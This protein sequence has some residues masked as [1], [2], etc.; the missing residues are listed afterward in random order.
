MN[1][2]L[3]GITLS[4]RVRSPQAEK[5]FLDTG[6]LLAELV[7]E[8]SLQLSEKELEPLRDRA[9]LAIGYLGDLLP[10]VTAPP[11]VAVDPPPEEVIPE[12]VPPKPSKKKPS[13]A[14]PVAP[15]APVAPTP[16]V[17][18]SLSDEEREALQE[19]QESLGISIPQDPE[20]I[21]LDS[22]S[23][24]PDEDLEESFE[25]EDLVEEEQV[26]GSATLELP[27]RPAIRELAASLQRPDKSAK[28]ALFLREFQDDNKFDPPLTALEQKIAFLCYY[29]GKEMKEIANEL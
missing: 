14:A 11:V 21:L 19:A 5:L 15:K 18:N 26:G 7:A 2:H 28:L 6:I 8:L 20:E 17:D 25:E 22:P 24:E 1:L 9:S 29:S 27:P 10:L 13:T 3:S 23:V 4:D 12:V 16:P